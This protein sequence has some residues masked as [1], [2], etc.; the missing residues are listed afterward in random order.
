MII[1]KYIYRSFQIVLIISGIIA[2]F[3]IMPFFVKLLNILI[4]LLQLTDTSPEFKLIL[5]IVSIYLICVLIQTIINLFS[6]IFS[7]FKSEG[8]ND[9][10]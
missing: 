8:Y 5:I 10:K 1:N 7:I 6:F 3:Q 4:V 9:K 2:I